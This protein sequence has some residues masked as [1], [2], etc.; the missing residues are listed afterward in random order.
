[1]LSIKKKIILS[2]LIPSLKTF[3]ILLYVEVN[4]LKIKNIATEKYQE[5]GHGIILKD[6]NFR[7]GD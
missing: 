1:M 5:S 3:L 2:L 7:D 6:A 4:L